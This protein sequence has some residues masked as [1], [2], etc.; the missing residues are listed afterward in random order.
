MWWR[1]LVSSS[2]IA[3]AEAQP[4]AR[5]SSA[6]IVSREHGTRLRAAEDSEDLLVEGLRDC[7]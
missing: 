3:C 5:V 1:V 4:P 2:L 7:F 6:P